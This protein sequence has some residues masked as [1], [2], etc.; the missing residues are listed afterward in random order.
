MGLTERRNFL[1]MAASVPL[2][3]AFSFLDFTHNPG[4]A[5]AEEEAKDDFRA[6]RIFAGSSK[7]I[8]FLAGRSGKPA[9]LLDV[10]GPHEAPHQGGSYDLALASSDFRDLRAKYTKVWRPV[11]KALQAYRELD[12]SLIVRLDLRDNRSDP[13]FFRSELIKVRDN[14]SKPFRVQPFNEPNLVCEPNVEALQGGRVISPEEHAKDFLDLT[15]I[16]ASYKCISIT[17]PFA[18]RAVTNGV[19]DKEYYRRY[20]EFIK[21]SEEWTYLQNWVELGINDYFFEENENPFLYAI[22]LLNTAE[23]V[24]KRRLPF[25]ILEFALFQDR[26]RTFAEQTS[27]DVTAKWMVEKLPEELKEIVSCTLW[28]YAS[29]EQQWPEDPHH[30]PLEDWYDYCALRNASGKTPL[31]SE[32]ERLSV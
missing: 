1:L 10:W 21:E 32:L 16:C 28:N 5:H 31:F 25:H 15:L 27:K 22:D 19:T 17:T 24:F 4:L 14:T 12:L 2:A 9:S 6:P 30:T 18:Q 3:G 23:G 11:E 20:W 26:N 7:R 29:K 13:D 8:P